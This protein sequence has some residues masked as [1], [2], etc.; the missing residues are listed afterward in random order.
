MNEL[1]LREN[2]PEEIKSILN[3][4][5]NE[6]V[7]KYGK[8]HSD[9][10]K[11]SIEKVSKTIVKKDS[12]CAP[13][14]MCSK[15]FG[16][17]YSKDERLPAILKH[18]LWH[19]YNGSP[20]QYSEI[21]E[22]YKKIMDST[23]MLKTEY[24][25]KMEEYKIK[26]KNEPIRLQHLLTDYETFYNKYGLDDQEVEKWTEWFNIQTHPKDMTDNFKDWND[27]FY[28]KNHSSNSWYD[29]YIN[30]AQMIS[31]LI[32]KEKLLEMHLNA[33]EYKTGYTYQDMID[34]FDKKYEN[35]LD[36]NEK[37][38][39]KYPYLKI[40]EDTKSISENYRKKDILTSRNSLQSAMKTCIKAY[41]E[42]IENMKEFDEET[43]KK[44]YN[45]IKYMQ[46]HMMWNVDISKMEELEYVQEMKKVQDKF[47]NKC[48]SLKQ[49]KDIENMIETVG[50]KENNTYKKIEKG[51]IIAQKILFSNTKDD[52]QIKRVGEYSAKV[53]KD[54]LKGNLYKSVKVLFGNKLYN[55]LFEKFNTENSNQL[56]ELYE[57]IEHAN[58]DKEILNTYN[59]IYKL[60]GNRV[61]NQIKIDENSASVN[62]ERISDDIEKMQNY[63]IMNKNAHYPRTLESVIEIYNKK[64]MLYLDRIEKNT[65]SEIKLD[66]ANGRNEESS[67]RFWKKLK[68]EEMEKMNSYDNKITGIRKKQQEY[69]KQKDKNITVEQIGKITINTPTIQKDVAKNKILNKVHEKSQQNEKIEK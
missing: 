8:K 68:N 48:S 56:T 9:Y 20:A 18:E 28:T 63:S 35:T 47:K 58:T 5:Y 14:A 69:F 37:A 54:G 27:G 67:R 31:V 19:V 32:P 46:E 15:G 10:I 17:S 55:Q 33:D 29:C 41:S 59:I 44:T 25:K 22:K 1:E 16:I 21:P 61:Q 38:K 53:G 13:I 49:T 23:G 40:L 26:W 60:F 30:I 24:E 52:T 39:Y 50:F 51:N 45:E 4:A 2:S 12:Y 62:F 64:A 7:E 36:N 3:D 42:K 66:L 65:E 6:F 57:K 11:K 34:E 43:A